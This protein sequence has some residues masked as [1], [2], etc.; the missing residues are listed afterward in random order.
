MTKV[1]PVVNAS[2]DTRFG[3]FAGGIGLLLNGAQ[4]AEYLAG[5]KVFPIPRVGRRVRGA[6]QI[7][8]HAILVFNADRLAPGNIAVVQTCAI[9]MLK[10]RDSAMAIQVTQAPLLL[11]GLAPADAPPPDICFS[12]SLSSPQTAR[13]LGST[14]HNELDSKVWWEADFDRFFEALGN[15]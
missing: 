11:N 5:I 6:A 15:D 1:L 10:G 7:R 8:G 9:V 4:S 3:V 2:T 14:A 13:V 12:V